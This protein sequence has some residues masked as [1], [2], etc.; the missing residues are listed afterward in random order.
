MIARLTNY[1]L[2]PSLATAPD[3]ELNTKSHAP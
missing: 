1:L 2:Q 3:L